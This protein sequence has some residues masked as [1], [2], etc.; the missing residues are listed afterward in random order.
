MAPR[1]RA[2]RK[3]AA[4][5]TVEVTP[6]PPAPEQEPD[7][8]NPWYKIWPKAVVDKHLMRQAQNREMA[9][10]KATHKKQRMVNN[11]V[12]PEKQSH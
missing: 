4:K 7:L 6:P 12:P 8:S 5:K 1:K 3:A 2:P 9:T 10:H 11:G